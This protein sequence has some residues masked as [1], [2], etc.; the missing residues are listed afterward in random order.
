MPSPAARG[1]QGEGTSRADVPVPQGGEKGPPLE[2][3]E[4][5]GRGRDTVQ[6]LGGIELIHRHSTR[7]PDGRPA[8]E[9]VI[10]ERPEEKRL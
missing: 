6:D 4:P 2:G 1:F 5:P 7:T 3:G 9:Q 8:A 10:G